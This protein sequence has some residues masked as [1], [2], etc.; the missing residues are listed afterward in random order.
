MGRFQTMP[1]GRYPVQDIPSSLVA[2]S[3]TQEKFSRQQQGSKFFPRQH[4]G[5]LA[6]PMRQGSRFFPRTA[7]NESFLPKT[8]ST[9]K[10]CFPR[11]KKSSFPRTKKPFLPWTGTIPRARSKASFFPSSRTEKS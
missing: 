4:E 5:N 2:P 3:F 1:S 9:E 7:R 6:F 11:T 10:S 8:T